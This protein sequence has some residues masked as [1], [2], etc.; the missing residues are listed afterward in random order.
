MKRPI[1]APPQSARSGGPLLAK[2]QKTSHV[3]GSSGSSLLSFQNSLTSSFASKVY[4]LES[5]VG[6]RHWL[7]TGTFKERILITFLN[8]V[9]PRKLAAK[10]GFVAFPTE[11]P[12]EKAAKNPKMETLNRSEYTLSKQIDILVYNPYDYTPVYEDQDI[13]ILPPEAL[14]HVVEVKGNLT[15]SSLTKAISHL[16]DFCSK[17][18]SYTKFRVEHSFDTELKLPELFVYAWQVHQLSGEHIRKQLGDHL[19]AVTNV[20]NYRISPKIDSVF[21]FGVSHTTL[22]TEISTNPS[23]IGY[24]TGR[25]QN[26]R[27]DDSGK[28][29]YAGD[30]TMFSL[31]RSVL[32]K[33]DLLTNRFLVRSD[34]TSYQDEPK[35]PNLGYLQVFE[36]EHV[37]E[38]TPTTK[39]R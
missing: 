2:I 11:V 39:S 23:T 24:S 32:Y 16:E 36:E 10:S 19:S 31:L 26:V 7:T 30:K 5:L 21:I 37:R 33:N 27:F 29:Q 4:L 17:W 8:E 18:K 22:T 1:V 25:G 15:S 28:A 13:V 12:S 9:L 35:D 14:S 20:K 34:E 3:P 38:W 6:G